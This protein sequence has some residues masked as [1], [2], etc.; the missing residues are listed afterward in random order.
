M[1]INVVQM[2]KDALAEKIGPAN[3]L[4]AKVKSAAKV[5][6][7]VISEIRNDEAKGDEYP[8]LKEF[9]EWEDKLNA[10]LI[11]K[12]EEVN[13]RIRS[14]I[15]GDEGNGFDVEAAAEELK[16]MV[17]EI[18]TELKALKTLDEAAYDEVAATLQA[19]SVRQSSGSG[20]TKRPRLREAYVDGEQVR[21]EETGKVSFTS[22]AKWLSKK[23]GATVAGSDLQAA[24]FTAAETDTLSD[25]SGE[26]VTFEFTVS[27]DGAPYTVEVV[28]A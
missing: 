12:R 6:G 10:A 13:A 18:K 27:E 11:A 24:A 21:D 17:A 8:W 2:M 19:A 22:L 1:A 16:G 5:S 20:D 3:E 7:K 14:E 26:T 15:V 9:Q 28:P 4:S 23:S 25:V